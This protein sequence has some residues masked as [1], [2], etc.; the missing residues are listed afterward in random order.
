MAFDRGGGGGDDDG[1]HHAALLESTVKNGDVNQLSKG[2]IVIG[3]VLGFQECT[4]ASKNE[5]DKG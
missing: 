1:L 2:F 4:D 5:H 3:F